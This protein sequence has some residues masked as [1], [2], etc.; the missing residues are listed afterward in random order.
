MTR[1]L[2][3]WCRR[4]ALPVCLALPWVAGLALAAPRAPA[5]LKPAVA[6]SGLPSVPAS[7]EARL[8]EVYQLIR[9]G[10]AR[11][12]L[13]RAEALTRDV[14]N[15][16]LAQ[17]VYGDLLL[18]RRQPLDAMGAAPPE[19][20]ASSPDQLAQLRQE[21]T[22]RL[23][24]LTERPPA[25]ALPRPF[26]DIPPST[27]HAIAVDA[28]RSRLYLFANDAKGL[29]LI[30]DHYV[31]LG[32]L[33]VD[34][35]EQGDQRTPLGAYFIT[36][37]LTN[38]Q[39]ADFYGPGALTLNYPNEYDRRRGKTGGG[40]WL[41]GVPPANFARGPQTTD[42][43]VVLANPD[44]LR[45]LREV[46]PRRTPV[47]IAPK[48]EWVARAQVEQERAAAHAMVE[49]WRVARSQGDVRKLLSF[50]SPQ[51]Q[52]GSADLAQW[53]EMV[54]KELQATRGRT[55]ELKE[56]SILSWRDAGEVLIVTFGEVLSGQ[57]TGPLKRQYWGKESGQWKIFFEGVIS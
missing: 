20:A 49:Q 55:A 34:K 17:L 10:D 45:L 43:C 7:P 12:A 35:K 31:S 54:D 29:H 24:A 22:L 2:R 6:R 42:G 16:Q 33:G 8:I 11:T 5:A 48:I 47:V 28:S 44:L 37:R 13:A 40:I 57:L 52:S 23:A 15:F 19:L 27:R 26:T 1:R 18:A 25:D 9:D 51:F 50:Y 36:S 53:S 32:R 41:H 21:A 4:A 38:Q 46:S 14:P 3:E 56:M 39:V 30:A